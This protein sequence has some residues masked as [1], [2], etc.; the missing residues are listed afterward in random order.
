MK[1][2]I[3][4]LG[5]VLVALGIGCV[6]D[7]DESSKENPYTV[8]AMSVTEQIAR[9]EYLV[10]TN[11]CNLCHSPKTFTDNGMEVDSSRLL[12]GH[13]ASETL[14]QYDEQ[15]A[16]S[17]VL[18][19]RG[20]TSATGPWGTSFAANLTPDPTGI[21]TWTEDQFMKAIREGLFKGLEGSRPLL[22]PM[23]WQNYRNFTDDDLKSIFAYLMSLE[24]VKNVV[25]E[26][27]P[28]IG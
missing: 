22:H 6:S 25:P 16:Q 11:A 8:E 3:F 26:P 12:S 10:S 1:P 27:I 5:F 23:P 7:T 24:P 17:Y 2:T 20:L 9:G 18:F 19:S 21:G 14:P 15:T 28:P 4:S 13:P